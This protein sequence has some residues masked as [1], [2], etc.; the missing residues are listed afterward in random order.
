MVKEFERQ[1]F[2]GKPFSSFIRVKVGNGLSVNFWT[3][4]WVGSTLLKHWWP[5]LYKLE[6]NKDCSVAERM[7]GNMEG[8]RF[9]PKWKRGLATVEEISELQDVNFLLSNVLLTGAKDHWFWGED[10]KD[11]FTVAEV[12][13]LVR[14]EKEV[15]RDHLM[16][17][18]SWVPNKVNIFVWRAEM[19][20]IPTKV[21]LINRRINIQDGLCSLCD[22]GDEDVMHLFTGCGF[23]SGVWEAIGRWC[24]IGSLL[25]FDFKDILAIH[26]QVSGGKWAKKVIRGVVMI[27]CWV[28]W[29]TRN[30][31]VFRDITPSVREVIALVK[32]WSFLWLKSRSKFSDLMWKDWVSNPVYML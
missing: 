17:W 32:S 27:T 14:E 5:S 6:Q 28:V 20:R 12:K 19:E 1:K 7:N 15:G 2:K 9:N 23:V 13:R 4:L 22:A 8:T 24:K 30:A 26:E 10:D 18:E 16:R 29:K 11:P 3:D 31:K 21:A 25:A